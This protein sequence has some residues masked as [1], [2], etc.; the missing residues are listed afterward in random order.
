MEDMTML[1]LLRYLRFFPNLPYRVKGTFKWYLNNFTLECFDMVEFL[2]MV[3]NFSFK[4]PLIL[5]GRYRENLGGFKDNLGTENLLFYYLNNTKLYASCHCI[6]MKDITQIS[7]I[8]KQQLWYLI[9]T[10]PNLLLWSQNYIN[11]PLTKHL[12]QSAL[13]NYTWTSL[14]S[15]DRLRCQ[16]LM[17]N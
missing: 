11:G 5:Y 17:D 14:L 4:V 10:K 9:T 3:H 16:H 6:I 15:N 12:P 13:M 2:G 8:H 1:P 7:H